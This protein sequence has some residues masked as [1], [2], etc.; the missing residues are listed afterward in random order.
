MSEANVRVAQQTYDAFGRGDVPAVLENF[1]TDVEWHAAEGLPWG[2]VHNGREAVAQR[3]FGSLMASF[4]DFSVN[5]ERFVA[6]EDV[7]VVL[8]R[9]AGKGKESG[10]P[11][12]AAFAH[13]WE[14][15]DGKLKRF[16]HHTDTVK[17]QQ[18]MSVEEPRPLA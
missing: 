6:S 17:F 12:D 10:R 3:V 11:L 15:E 13:V 2:G 9:Y 1:H 5:P 8:G 16:Y 4:D 18:A 7:V 14:F